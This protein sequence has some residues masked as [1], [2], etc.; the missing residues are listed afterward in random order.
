L[1]LDLEQSGVLDADRR[2]RRHAP[3][4]LL[5]LMREGKRAG[6]LAQVERPHQLVVVLDGDA[7]ERRHRN[8]LV[9]EAHGRG[10][11]GDGF[12]TNGLAARQHEPEE[13]LA[14]R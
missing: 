3:H 13:P 1:L 4:E 11:F 14:A 5:V 10:M 9:R 8:V 7:E 6:R 2:H 12:D